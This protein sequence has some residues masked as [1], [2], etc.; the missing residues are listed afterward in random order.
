[1]P[2]ESPNQP[3]YRVIHLAPPI[4]VLRTTPRLREPPSES[5]FNH[6][7]PPPPSTTSPPRKRFRLRRRLNV[8]S[9]YTHPPDG[10][11]SDSTEILQSSSEE[12]E[13][14]DSEEGR[15]NL[16][17]SSASPHPKATPPQKIRRI[18][19]SE[20]PA[21]YSS[22]SHHRRPTPTVNLPPSRPLIRARSPS[23]PS[24]NSRPRHGPPPP[25][26]PAASLPRPSEKRVSWCPTFAAAGILIDRAQCAV[27]S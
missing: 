7:Q 13:E 10:Y 9:T 25:A 22:S 4:P 15:W 20:S 17:E 11:K 6:L 5:L 26:P 27:H 21:S 1:M 3:A 14:N 8:S 12:E 19:P 16:H 24:T 2:P 23:P 18:G